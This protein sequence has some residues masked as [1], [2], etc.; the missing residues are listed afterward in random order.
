MSDH[1]TVQQTT[2]PLKI[3]PYNQEKKKNIFRPRAKK[4][5][6]N[7]AILTGLKNISMQ[8]S[9]TLLTLIDIHKKR[10]Y[11]IKIIEIIKKYQLI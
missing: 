11:I 3:H 10:N 5:K 1:P 2:Q 7:F 8:N 9:Q 6:F 4:K